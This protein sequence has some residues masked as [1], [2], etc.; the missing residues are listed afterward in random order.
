[1][2]AVIQTGAKQYKVEK[3]SKI[4]VEKLDVKEGAEIK[5]ENVL[6]VSEKGKTT[7]GMPLVK[8]AS[9][10][11]K[12]L[13]QGK[14]EKIRVF[15]MKAKKRYQITQGHRQPITTLEITDISVGSS[16]TTTAKKTTKKEETA[17]A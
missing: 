9:V 13:S 10:K 2:F 1:M 16:G 17:E 8:G 15:K 3:G 11:A 6:L 7:I 5:L 4:T 12:V 14:D